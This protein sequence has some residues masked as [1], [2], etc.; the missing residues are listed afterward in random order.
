MSKSHLSHC[1]GLQSSPAG[2]SSVGLYVHVCFEKVRSCV[3]TC[4]LWY[5]FMSAYIYSA[6]E[7]CACLSTALQ[8][9]SISDIIFS[10]WINVLMENYKE[11]EYL[12]TKG[13]RLKAEKIK[14]CTWELTSH[15]SLLFLHLFYSQHI[16]LQPKIAYFKLSSS[17]RTLSLFPSSPLFSQASQMIQSVSLANAVD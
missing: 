5:F 2:V 16:L 13:C 3:A 7:K 12:E 15:P 9:L 6:S 11:N 10:I 17:L 8:I 14:Y 1:L 4:M